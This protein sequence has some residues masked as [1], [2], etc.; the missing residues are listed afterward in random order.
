M[1]RLCR[2]AVRLVEC[3][4]RMVQVYYAA[5]D[6]WDH[7]ADIQLHRK[8]AKDSDQPFAAVIKDLKSRGLFKDTLVVC[9]S[10]FRRTPVV[11]VGGGGGATQTGRGQN[12]DGHRIV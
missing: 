1:S 2:L 3:G 12:P 9:G 10:E 7:H 11:E 8:N 5:G 4:V 6:P